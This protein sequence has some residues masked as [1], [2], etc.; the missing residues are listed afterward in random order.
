MQRGF[1]LSTALLLPLTATGCCWLDCGRSLGPSFSMPSFSR[2]FDD[3]GGQLAAA[4]AVIHHATTLSAQELLA[5]PGAKFQVSRAFLT[6][7]ANST[8]PGQWELKA[9][10]AL[11]TEAVVAPQQANECFPP[12]EELRD[13]L[14]N[15]SKEFHPLER[16]SGLTLQF[17]AHLAREQGPAPERI[18]LVF[19]VRDARAKPRLV[20]V[21][22]AEAA[23][24]G[25]SDIPAQPA[26]WSVTEPTSALRATTDAGSLRDR[27]FRTALISRTRRELRG[28]A[29][30]APAKVRLQSCR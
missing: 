30:R 28:P 25:T 14:R 8:H 6:S 1:A 19:Y 13:L 7:E 9:L 23:R 21:W 16:L 24:V 29:A 3:L 18:R 4:T 12:R 10:T 17:A 2:M 15:A 27:V 26:M 5:L 22:C 11:E 20:E